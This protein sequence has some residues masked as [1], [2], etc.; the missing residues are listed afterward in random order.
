[1]VWRLF[2]RG[3]PVM[4]P[5]LA[6][7]ILSLTLTI[8]RAAYVWRSRRAES[9]RAL[10]QT[11]AAL[12]RGEAEHAVDAA[13]RAGPAYGRL[14]RRLTANP[15]D[16]TPATAA[17]AVEAGRAE[18]ERFLPILSVIVT[19]APLLGIL[20]TVLGIIKSFDVVAEAA[21]PVELKD[22]AA[23]IAEA[24]LTTAAGMVIALLSLLPYALL[25][26]WSARVVV[27]IEILAE[28]WTGPVT[29]AGGADGASGVGAIPAERSSAGPKQAD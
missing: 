12:G 29:P 24:L 4:W 11:T 6:M 19:A 18:A 17:I 25:R 16:R 14:A 3:G 9:D 13:D 7:S 10:A 22:V 28:A 15:G 1:M 8:E 27:S 21:G 26:S 20:G 2:E 5:L 23:G